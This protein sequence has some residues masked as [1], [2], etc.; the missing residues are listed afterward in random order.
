MG[1]V[2]LILRVGESPYKH[3]RQDLFPTCFQCLPIM[4]ALSLCSIP[5]SQR[6]S[7]A[8]LPWLPYPFIPSLVPTHIPT[9]RYGPLAR[10][11]VCLSKCFNHSRPVSLFVHPLLVG[12]ITQFRWEATICIPI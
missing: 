12:L 2:F 10:A 11:V 7:S 8:F 1:L 5:C 6:G 3:E 9:I 4:A